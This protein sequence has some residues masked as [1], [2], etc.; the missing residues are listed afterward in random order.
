MVFGFFARK[1]QPPPETVPLPPSP[2]ASTSVNVNPSPPS[3]VEKNVQ[4]RTPSPS[5]ESASVAKVRSASPSTKIARLS[6]EERQASPTRRGSLPGPNPFTAIAP[7]PAFVPPE[8]TVESLTTHIAAIPPKVLHA[9]VLARIPNVPEDTLPTLAALFAELAPPPKVHC[10]RCHKDYVEV[11]NDDRSCL[12]PHDDESAEVER[13]GTARRAGRV[14]GTVGA[15]FETLWGCCGKVVEGDGDQGPPDGWCYEGM[16]TT[17]IK[18]ARFRADSTPHDDRLVSCLRLNCH[19]I[20]ATMPRGARSVRKR[21]RSVNL[22]EAST[23]ED[24]SEG[25]P[26]SGVDEIVGKTA[27]ASG[28]GRPKGSKNK[29]K[30]KGKGKARATAADADEDE[31]EHDQMD[32]DEPQAE[33]ASVAG[34]VRG[35]GRPPKSKTQPPGSAAK[36]R[37]RVMD[38][39]VVPGTDGEDDDDV[40]S[41]RSAP[42][43]EA[44]KRRGR[45]PKSKATISDSD[46]EAE[47]HPHTP[48][49]RVSAGKPRTRSLSRTRGGDASDASMGARPKSKARA[50]K[51]KE[52]NARDDAEAADGDDE[53]PKKRRRVVDS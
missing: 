28:R 13:V 35:R 47:G 11:E 31:D 9:Y 18:R 1:A 42:T 36:R 4:L 44:Q 37:A 30:G 2:T 7:N 19:G 14:P 32:V 24:E 40:Q 46:R 3:K 10:V 34:S 8:P 48:A 22:K 17:D 6:I 39:R 26:D 52:A 27:S 45:A 49:K 12:V 33:S 5:V 16:H 25:E 20:R 21:P 23:E 41:V 53:K 51:V 43:A 50:R 29:D 15:T 38:P